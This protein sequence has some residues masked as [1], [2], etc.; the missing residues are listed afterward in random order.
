MDFSTQLFIE[1]LGVSVPGEAIC[2]PV[3]CGTGLYDETPEKGSEN[4]CYMLV[5]EH[6]TRSD[7][8]DFIAEIKNK[9]GKKGFYRELYGNIFAEFEYEKY[10]LY[11]Y[12]T[13][14]KHTAR[15]I[16]DTVSV[17]LC[18][19]EYDDDKNIRDNSALMQFSL[20]Y[21]TMNYGYSC[22]CGM[23]YAIRLRDNSLILIDG[24]EKEQ[25]TDEATDELITRLYDLTG[26][27]KSEKLHISMW[28]GT[29]NHDDHMDV[30]IKLMRLLEG[31]MTLDRV[32]F[33][34]PSETLMGRGNPNVNLFK[35]RVRKYFPNV[36]FLK[37]HTGEKF[38]IPCGNIEI[39]STHEDILPRSPYAGEGKTYRGMNESTTVFKIEFDESSI[40]FLGDAEEA[41]GEVLTCLYGKNLLSSYYLQC[42]HHMINDD[43]NI[44][45]IIEAKKLLIPQ[46]RYISGL[47]NGE[48]THYLTSLFGAENMY[49][50]GDCTYVFTVKHGKEMLS[51]YEQKGYFYDN[52]E[53]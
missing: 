42:A 22:D 9:G 13:A 23:L 15:I 3:N 19:F 53:L 45:S 29:H 10:I 34:F 6:V 25:A 32:M 31:R 41:N 4:D 49:Y 40:I 52:S 12:Y 35:E 1:K 7:F 39:L 38:D 43:R 37:P 24:G 11:T 28:I 51:M 27:D 26:L 50:A 47:R 33:N 8:A 18:R 2:P 14:E 48:N 44:Y 36:M 46:C 16:L 5:T 30:F 20:K 21:G 17:P